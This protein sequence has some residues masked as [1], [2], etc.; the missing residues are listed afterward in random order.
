[1][2]DYSKSKIYSI[3][4]YDNDNIIY[5]GS[6]VQSLVMRFAGHKT[7]FECSLYQ[8]IQQNYDGDFKCCYIELLEPFECNNKQ[9]LNKKEGE[10]IRKYKTDDKYIVI[11]KLIAGRTN[12]EYRQEN[13]DKIKQRNQNYYQNNTD[14]IKEQRKKKKE[15]I[16]IN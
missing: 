10:M 8:Y 12:I 5:I 15:T 11:N 14:K 2:P 13:A 4:F 6:T 9:E 7:G 1:M 16:K 3:R